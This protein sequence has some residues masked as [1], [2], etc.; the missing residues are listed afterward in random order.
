VKA[1]KYAKE[2]A[3]AIHLTFLSIKD[4]KPDNLSFPVISDEYAWMPTARKYILNLFRCILIVEIL[5][6]PIYFLAS[7]EIKRYIL[8]ANILLQGIIAFVSMLSGPIFHKNPDDHIY[9]VATMGWLLFY[10]FN[11]P[12]NIY[13]LLGSMIMSLIAAF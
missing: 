5:S 7:G 3:S 13:P 12:E 2:D 1:F 4:K 8:L 10:Q 11:F 9:V 6:A